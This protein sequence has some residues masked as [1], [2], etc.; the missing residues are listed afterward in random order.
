MIWLLISLVDLHIVQTR[1]EQIKKIC[2]ICELSSYIQSM[3]NINI[4]SEA[5]FAAKTFS[6]EEIETKLNNCVNQ[7]VAR[8]A[9]KSWMPGQR[10]ASVAWQQVYSK[11]LTI[12]NS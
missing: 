7:M 1:G 12:L 11:A 4:E 8:D 3:L 10:E 6:R 2:C 9:K 5:K